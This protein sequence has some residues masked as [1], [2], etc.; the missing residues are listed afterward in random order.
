M[1]ELCGVRF[2]YPGSDEPAIDG[3]DWE[4]PRGAFVAV[5]G[6]NGSG[7]STLARLLNGL[8]VPTEGTVRVAGLDPS[9]PDHRWEIRRRV[10]LVFQNPENQIVATT[11]EDDVAFGPENLGLPP[12]E[13]RLRVRAALEAVGLGHL[14]AREVHQLSGG[15]KQR[16]AIAGVLALQPDCLVLDEPTSLLDP[17]GRQEVLHVLRN[18]HR[19]GKTVVLITHRMEEAALAQEVAVLHQGRLALRGRPQEVLAREAELVSFGLEPPE[20]VR[21]ARLLR[22]AGVAVPGVPLS[23]EELASALLSL[24]HDRRLLALP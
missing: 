24:A 16:L 1:I 22:R 10:G 5:V 17:A 18:L 20:A 21:A 14:A 13:I 12:A 19:Q 8:L 9:R 2:S 23:V 3:L 7:K 11:V 15:Q 4:I 6:S